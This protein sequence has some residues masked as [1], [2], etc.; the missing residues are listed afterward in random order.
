MAKHKK[1]N[2]FLG[3]NYLYRATYVTEKDYEATYDFLRR[4]GYDT[5]KDIHE[6]FIQ[7]YKRLNASRDI[8]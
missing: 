5:D 1:S 6:Q 4:I 8:I 7:K 2:Q 3:I